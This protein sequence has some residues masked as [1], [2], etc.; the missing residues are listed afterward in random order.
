MTNRLA[1]DPVQ[2]LLAQTSAKN[3]AFAP[4]SRYYGL[5]TTSLAAGDGTTIVYLE[6]RFLPSSSSFQVLQ[7]HTV[8]AGDRLDNLA[9]Q[10]L[11]DATLFWRL[12]DANDAMRPG[13]LTATVGRAIAITLPTGIAGTRL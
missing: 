8:A 12:C 7:R 9:A 10:F 13:E 5:S 4:T 6:R 1:L 11:G 3:N 2:A